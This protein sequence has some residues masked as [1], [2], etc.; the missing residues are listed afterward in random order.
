VLITGASSGIGEATARRCAEQGARVGLLARRG[1]RITALAE[2]LGGVAAAADVTD[3]FAAAEAVEEIAA[4]MGGLDAVVNNAGVMRPGV[5]AEQPIDEWRAMLDTNVLG[6]LAVTQA[7]IGHLRQAGGGDIVMMS[8]MSGRRV[9]GDRSG[10]Y[11]AT[12]HAVHAIAMSLRRE[13]QADHIRVTTVAP[14]FVATDLAGSIPD[15]SVREPMTARVA[16]LGIDPFH[17]AR[18]VSRVLAD[19]PEVSVL[20]IALLPSAQET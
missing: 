15:P 19:P 1:E 20:E 6:L 4:A 5:I 18:A 13:L 9:P 12:K 7:A 16:E 8:S 11:A 3:P 14:G 10:V 2:E 17:V